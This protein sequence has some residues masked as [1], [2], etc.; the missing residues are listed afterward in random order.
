MEAPCG[1][2]GAQVI[3][4]NISTANKSLKQNLQDASQLAPQAV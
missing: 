1:L 2:T 3:Y 4:P